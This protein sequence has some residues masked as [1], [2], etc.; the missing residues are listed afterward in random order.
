MKHTF[1]IASPSHSI[2]VPFSGMNS[3]RHK[4]KKS[5]K[6]F[7]YTKINQNIMCNHPYQ[8]SINCIHTKYACKLGKHRNNHQNTAYTKLPVLL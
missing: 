1:F 4:V 2:K 7:P 8:K 6:L 3:Q 5:L